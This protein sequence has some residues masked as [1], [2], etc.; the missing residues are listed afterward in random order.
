MISVLHIITTIRRGGA[1]NQLLTLARQQVATGKKIS[2]LFL[3]DSSE[4]SEDFKNSGIHVIDNFSNISP[5][6]QVIQLRRYLKK[7]NID[8]IHTH[9]PRAEILVRLTFVKGHYFFTRH[10]AE[11]FFPKAPIIISRLLSKFAT[12][13]NSR[14]IAIS[15]AVSNFCITE[16]EIHK[17]STLRTIYYGFDPGIPA[18][19]GENHGREFTFGTVARLTSQKDIPTLL[20][21]FAEIVGIYPL[22]KLLIVGKGE[23]ENDLK[24]LA[25]KLSIHDSLIWIEHTGDVDKYMR[26]IQT[27][28]LP[29][30]YE[31]FGLVLLEA[32]NARCAILAANN[33]AIPEVLG[34][35]F[36]GLFNTG[37]F[38]ELSKLMEAS[39][40][41]PFRDQLLS[42]QDIRLK[43][44]SPVIMETAIN[45]YYF[46]S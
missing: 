8:V 30:K 43:S 46:E 37:S 27:F 23:L 38:V 16:K 20:Q 17:N 45:D 39:L 33:S 35:D 21:S 13:G 36:P 40:S 6:S 14:G 24:N 25:I 32:M 2:V 5:L 26:Q 15:D 41:K 28:V 29:S 7:E 10:N 1:E 31:G 12:R 44:F 9:L 4:L 34:R 19:E 22:T 3:K 42:L 11:K 18:F